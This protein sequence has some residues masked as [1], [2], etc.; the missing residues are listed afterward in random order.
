MIRRWYSYFE[1]F[2]L[3]VY[4]ILERRRRLF[5]EEASA[6]CF[7]GQRAREATFE[8]SISRLSYP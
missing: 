3:L 4:G 5:M 6:K 7:C 1:V 8:K 2:K